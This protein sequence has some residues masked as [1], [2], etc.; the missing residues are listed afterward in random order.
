MNLATAL[1]DTIRKIR[2]NKGMT[3][4]DLSVKSNTSLGYLS[5][6][7]RGTKEVSSTV[8]DSIARG[9]GVTLFQIVSESAMSIFLSQNAETDEPQNA[10]MENLVSL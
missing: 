7:E 4:R 2:V 3:L 5:E 10:S 6:I 1:G 9:L 8:L